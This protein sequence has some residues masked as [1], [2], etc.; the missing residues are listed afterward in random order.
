M[1]DECVDD[2][3]SK[4]ND[5]YV[6]IEVSNTNA[7]D[8]DINSIIETIKNECSITISDNDIGWSSDNECNITHNCQ[9][10]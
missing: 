6:D 3:F 7:I 9:P 5:V 10:E 1:N 2:L 4:V 8:L